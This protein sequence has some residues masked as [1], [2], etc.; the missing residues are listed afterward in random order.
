MQVFA[1]AIRYK[2][3]VILFLHCKVLQ[4]HYSFIVKLFRK[5]LKRE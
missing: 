3:S 4:K 5:R 2:S 1:V